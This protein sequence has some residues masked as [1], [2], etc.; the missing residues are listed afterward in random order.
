M[1]LVNSVNKN[2]MDEKIHEMSGA[3]LKMGCIHT[4][5]TVYG[6]FPIFFLDK[7]HHCQLINVQQ[8]G[9]PEIR[10]IASIK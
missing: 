10:E 2:Q 9:N 6:K 3:P 4:D 7:F 8:L 1:E 5:H